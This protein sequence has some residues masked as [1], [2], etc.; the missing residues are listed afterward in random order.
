M[1]LA[2]LQQ[3]LPQLE[4]YCERLYNAQVRLAIFHAAVASDDRILVITLRD[5]TRR[6]QMSARKR[7]NHSL[8]SPNP[9]TISHIYG[10]AP[11]I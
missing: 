2:T 3:Q 9:L 1:D 5:H 11:R 10:C 6:I 8:L 7:S 4:F